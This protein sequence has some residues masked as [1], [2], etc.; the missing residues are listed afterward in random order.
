MLPI[1]VPRRLQCLFFRGTQLVCGR[2]GFPRRGDPRPTTHHLH[3]RSPVGIRQ[4]WGLLLEVYHLMRNRC[5][6]ANRMRS[7]ML[8]YAAY[9]EFN[10]NN[11]FANTVFI[12]VTNRS[13]SALL[14]AL[15]VG[16][17]LVPKYFSIAPPR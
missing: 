10:S 5:L 13:T 14:V 3:T 15:L 8:I 12:R 11:F 6:M 9:L 16:A 2:A 17:L 4:E 7:V 1:G